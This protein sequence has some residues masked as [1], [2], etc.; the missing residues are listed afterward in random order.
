MA[1]SDT[2]SGFQQEI[3]GTSQVVGAIQCESRW[4]L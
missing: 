2:Q 3:M 4:L 1:I